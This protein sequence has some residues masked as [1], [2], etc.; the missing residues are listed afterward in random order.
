MIHVPETA[1]VR[2][3]GEIVHPFSIE[4]LREGYRLA[5]LEGDDVEAYFEELSRRWGPDMDV[6]WSEDTLLLVAMV[7]ESARERVRQHARWT[8][9]ELDSRLKKRRRRSG[10]A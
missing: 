1:D 3:A 2:L 9:E 7:S 10:G 4:E 5:G 8:D 6:A